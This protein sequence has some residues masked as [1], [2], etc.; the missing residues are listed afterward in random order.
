MQ[1]GQLSQLSNVPK[2][3]IRFYEQK[4]LMPA[5]KRT[6]SGYRIYDQEALNQLQLIKFSQSLG[7]ALDELP[8]L[9]DNNGN[10]DHEIII[11]RLQEKQQETRQLI[12]QLNS[13]QRKLDE[14]IEQLQNTWQAGQCLSRCELN[15]ILNQTQYQ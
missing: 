9:V 5:A 13:K 2:S 8:K 14:L 1:I 3:T 12:S 7:F 6:S 10:W 4:G 11:S 15:K